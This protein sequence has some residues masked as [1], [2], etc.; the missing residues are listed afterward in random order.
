MPAQADY[1]QIAH[2]ARLAVLATLA[3][4]VAADEA[5][6]DEDIRAV[7]LVVTLGNSGSDEPAATLT[8]YGTSNV[9]IGEVAL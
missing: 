2:I 4:G 6:R 8:F 3:R 7:S 5:A 1:D 9:P